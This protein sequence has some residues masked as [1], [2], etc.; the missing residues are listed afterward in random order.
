MNEL[1][2]TR[3]IVNEIDPMDK[4]SSFEEIKETHEI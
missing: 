4:L 1:I 2:E 3:K